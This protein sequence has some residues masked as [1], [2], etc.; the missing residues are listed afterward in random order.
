EATGQTGFSYTLSGETV[1]HMPEEEPNDLVSQALALSMPGEGDA[2][3]SSLMDIDFF[4]V[5]AGPMDVGKKLHVQT[6][7]GDTNTDTL[8]QILRPDG[9]STLTGPVDYGYQENVTSA[10]L[11]MAGAYYVKISMSTY[12]GTFNPTQSHY[13]V[14]VTLE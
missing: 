1:P 8:V 4:K 11:P 7:P 13:E 9:M 3:L 6:L 5:T 10:P 2:Q 12:Q 14:L